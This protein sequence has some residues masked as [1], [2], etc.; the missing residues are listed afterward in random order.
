MDG[1]FC[2]GL[3]GRMHALWMRPAASQAPRNL[4]VKSRPHS[5][6]PQPGAEAWQACILLAGAGQAMSRSERI[7]QAGHGALDRRYFAL[8]LAA[9]IQPFG[10]ATSDLSVKA[11]QCAG[12][13]HAG[14][15][16]VAGSD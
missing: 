12:I 13:E 16:G 11:R 6:L 4:P 2:H 7:G 9:R 15:S 5:R 3:P 10:R 8:M 14:A 1:E